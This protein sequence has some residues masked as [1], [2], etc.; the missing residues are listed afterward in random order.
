MCPKISACPKLPTF[1]IL[2]YAYKIQYIYN[3]E[4]CKTIYTQKSKKK[5]FKIKNYCSKKLV[6]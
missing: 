2:F 6:N 4:N 5:T 1:T 3:T